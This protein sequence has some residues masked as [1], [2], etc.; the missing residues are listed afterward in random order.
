MQQRF[1]LEL[2]PLGLGTLWGSV[3]CTRIIQYPYHSAW[4]RRRTTSFFSSLASESCSSCLQSQKQT[5]QTHAT[6]RRFNKLAMK[7]I[8][9]GRNCNQEHWRLNSWR[10]PGR[11]RV[12]NC[13]TLLE[14]ATPPV[15]QGR[16]KSSS[17][18]NVSHPPLTTI[19]RG[20]MVHI[21][22]GIPSASYTVHVLECCMYWDTI[23]SRFFSPLLASS[24]LTCW[25]DS[26]LHNTTI[27]QSIS[28]ACH[29]HKPKTAQTFRHKHITTS[30]WTL[31]QHSLCNNSSS[32]REQS[33]A[34]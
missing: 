27:R 10:L 5:S 4:I 31:H 13:K 8:D 20:D 1:Y 15:F 2:N 18:Y 32:E 3:P 21:R 17:F 7:L 11:R 28:V 14:K 34:W 22:C 19:A 12:E 26:R 33:A 25:Y 23:D 6:R 24:S 30:T 29:W 9:E 16:E